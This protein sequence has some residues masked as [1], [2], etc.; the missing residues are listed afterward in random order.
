MLAKT[1]GCAD[2]LRRVHPYL[3]PPIDGGAFPRQEIAVALGDRGALGLLVPLYG[4]PSEGTG[5][6]PAGLG[7]QG[8]SPAEQD[9]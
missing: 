8:V 1:L 7:R 2:V 9:D 4:T 6:R 3:A 5:C